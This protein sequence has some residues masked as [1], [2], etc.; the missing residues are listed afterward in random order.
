MKNQADSAIFGIEKLLRDSPDKLSDEDKELLKTE[1]D[2]LKEIMAK[3]DITKEELE[4]AVQEFSTATQ[5]V[6]VK[7]YQQAQT[8]AG[9]NTTDGATENPS[10]ENPEAGNNK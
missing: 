2:K 4:K 1:S 7:L 6:V 8:D 9:A 3:E 5:A 10:D